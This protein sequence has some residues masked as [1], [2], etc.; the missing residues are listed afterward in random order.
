MPLLI[1]ELFLGDVHTIS[2]PTDAI[3]IISL[4]IVFALVGYFINNISNNETNKLDQEQDIDSNLKLIKKE[5]KDELILEA[6]TQHNTN[7]DRY[8]INKLNFLLPSKLL[9]LSSYTLVAIGGASL[10]GIKQMQKS[11]EGINTSQVSIKLVNKSTQSPFSMD[12]MK[13]LNNTQTSIKK[14]SYITPYL[15]T[16]KSSKDNHSFQVKEKKLNN[17]FSF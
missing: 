12:N 7:L 15:S 3:F 9:R 1:T 8:R 17:N 5:C 4:L 2:I 6:T 10:L 13:S 14:I 16:V 11:Y